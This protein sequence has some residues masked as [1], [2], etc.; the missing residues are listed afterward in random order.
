M[1]LACKEA[2]RLPLDLG[3]VW[4]T[5]LSSDERRRLPGL[6]PA[7]SSGPKQGELL[8][9]T[10]YMLSEIRSMLL[11]DSCRFDLMIIEEASQAYLATI[12][13]FASMAS[14]LLVIGDHRQLFP[15]VKREHEARETYPGVDRVIHG[16]RTYTFNR[17]DISYRLTNTRRLTSASA[18]LTGIY[19]GRSLRSI[20]RLEGRTTFASRFS[21]LFH[22]NGGVTMARLPLTGSLFSGRSVLG[23]IA[24]VARDIMDTDPEMEMAIL[25]PHAMYESE[26]YVQYSRISNNLS[27]LT[28]STVHK[29]QGLTTGLTIYFLP[30]TRSLFG[31]SD[32]IFN[33]ATSRANRGTL[34]VA[35]SDIDLKKSVSAETRLFIEGCQDVTKK[36]ME[37]LS[38]ENGHITSTDG[39]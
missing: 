2:L 23:F 38:R 1:E 30:S 27:R 10:Y 15:I 3:K 18:A 33:V 31:L 26:A 32:N 34:I 9:S 24:A 17:N 35:Y 25:T 5:N 37:M 6:K 28:I 7:D 12:G 13:M 22:N 21:G 8:L 14:M 39:S 4:K 16:L 20:S 11:P 36:F 29:I 19:Y